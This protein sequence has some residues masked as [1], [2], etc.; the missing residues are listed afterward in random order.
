VALT[1]SKAPEE[2]AKWTMQMLADKLVELKI[3]DEISDETVRKTL[4]K[5]NSNPGDRHSGSSQR[6]PVPSSSA[7]W[8]TS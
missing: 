3:V 6:M 7:R 8:K 4:K 1:C 5:T 2:A